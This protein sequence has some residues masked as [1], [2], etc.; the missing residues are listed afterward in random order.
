MQERE[1]DFQ[2]VEW[3]KS[4]RHATTPMTTCHNAVISPLDRTTVTKAAQS[5][6]AKEKRDQPGTFVRLRAKG[7]GQH[8]ECK[9][10][11]QGKADADSRIGRADDGDEGGCGVNINDCLC[12]AAL[13]A[14]VI[15]Q[16]S[17]KQL[18]RSGT[19]SPT[20]Q[21]QQPFVATTRMC[22]DD[23][24]ESSWTDAGWR[25]CSVDLLHE[26]RNGRPA[27]CP[28]AF[29]SAFGAAARLDLATD[30]ASSS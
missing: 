30:E 22:W 15:Y 28:R 27:G 18:S 12:R 16:R 3:P 7:T 10:G 24:L 9:R 25:A 14:E 23:V 19:R 29:A 20:C 6:D 11:G 26:Q 8:R 1:K 2:T 21:T 4:Y 13:A 5:R 17:A